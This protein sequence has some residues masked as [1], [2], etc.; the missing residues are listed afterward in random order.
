MMKRL[1]LFLAICCCDIE[2]ANAG[3]ASA[4]GEALGKA[5]GKAVKVVDDVPI[6]KHTPDVAPI[7]K[8]TFDPVPASEANFNISSQVKKMSDG[9]VL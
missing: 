6:P 3:W 4:I 2:I 9:L 7:P 1:V 5:S 8:P